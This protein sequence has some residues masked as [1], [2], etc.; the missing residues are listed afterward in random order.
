MSGWTRN[1]NKEPTPGHLSMEDFAQKLCPSPES[2]SHLGVGGRALGPPQLGLDKAAGLLIALGALLKGGGER[3]SVLILVPSDRQLA[4][5][6]GAVQEGEAL[7]EATAQ[8]TERLSEVDEVIGD[9]VVIKA[10]LAL[11]EG[12]GAL[13]HGHR[14]NCIARPSRAL[15][16]CWGIVPS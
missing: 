2:Q 12:D 8:L 10:E 4:N 11:R 14:S 3:P 5:G 7:V 9:E 6:N 16:T 15:P 13:E 1:C